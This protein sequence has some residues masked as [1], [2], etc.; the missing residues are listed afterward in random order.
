MIG[1]MMRLRGL[2]V[3]EVTQVRRDPSSLLIA[4]LLPLVLLLINGFSITLDARAVRLAVVIDAPSA[5]TQELF[6]AMASSPYLAPIRV[7]TTDDGARLIATGAARG[8]LVLR[9]DFAETLL[10][11]QR[12]PAHIGLQVSGTD[13]NTAR[14]VEGY[15]AGAIQTWLAGHALENRLL[16]TPAASLEHRDWFNA[17]LRSSNSIIPGMIAFVMSMTGTLLTALVVAREWERGTMESM[18]ASPARMAELIAAKLGVYFVL[19]MISMM[20]AMLV[21]TLVFEVPFRGGILPLLA[22]AALFLLFA[23][24]L[25]LFISTLV[26]NQFLASQLA[27][28]VTMLPAMMLSGMLFDIASM[29][30][31]LQLL[32]YLFP[33]R[34]LVSILQTLFLAGSVTA[35][36]LPNL[37]ALALSAVVAVAAT[38]AVTRRRL[39]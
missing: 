26:R 23:L 27:F 15:V 39:D 11:P 5:P 29:P 4:F 1:T 30:R 35:V 24:A 34:Y 14:L 18:L 6:Q 22:A 36:L 37:G 31:W 7:A 2:L 17:E 19:G 38:L 33:A 16:A 25:G 13:P 3:K 10:R 12:W 9:E 21:G 8:M 20:E 32:T 28:L